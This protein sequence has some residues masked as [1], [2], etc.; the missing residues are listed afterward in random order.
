MVNK[1]MIKIAHTDSGALTL[2]IINYAMALISLLIIGRAH[3]ILTRIALVTGLTALNI[4]S[5]IRVHLNLVSRGLLGY[6]LFLVNILPYAVL[7]IHPG[8]WLVMP[9]IPLILFILEVVRGRGRSVIANVSGMALIASSFI[10]W[11]VLMGGVLPISIT[12]ISL[13]W[14]IYHTFNA[15]YV[16]GKM[17]FRSGVKPWHASILWLTAL[18][19]LAYLMYTMVNPLFLFVL[20]EPTARALVAIRERKLSIDNIRAKVRRIGI[21]LAIESLALATLILFLLYII[22]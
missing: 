17:P 12:A 1:L 22:S 19:P 7:L 16:E 10:A 4:M 14:V 9:A 15:L 13:M 6:L 2:L 20:A 21:G 5:L 18:P 8:L 11:Y 3:L